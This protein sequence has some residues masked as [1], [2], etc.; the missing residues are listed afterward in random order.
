MAVTLATG[1]VQIL[2]STRGFQ[3]ALGRELDDE[4][5]RAGERAGDESSKRFSG[6]FAS[7]IKAGAKVAAT[8]F[9]AALAGAAVLGKASID[10]ASDLAEAQSKVNV[11]FG[12][13]AA[14]VT[15]WS[16]TA[17]KRIGAS[18]KVALDAAGGFGNLFTQLGI[19]A[20][21]AGT[22]STSMV[23][24]AADFA[25]FHNADIT[26]VLEAQA[27]AFRGE[28]DSVQRFVPTINA[29]AVEQKA[30]EMGL[31][32]TSG[33]LDAQDKALATQALIM[34][35]AGQATGDFARTSDGLAN[36]QRILSAQFEN[37][38]ASLGEKLI[39]AMTTVV[40][41]I[42]EKV[43]PWVQQL[44][45]KWMP[46]L[47]EG[48]QHVSDWVRTN[49]PQ[50]RDT[51]KSVM[52]AVR[53]VI[54][55]AVDIIR[56]IWENFG[57]QIR[58]IAEGKFKMIIGVIRGGFEIVRGIFETVSALL[59]GDWSGVWD[60]L[61]R[62]VL[63]AWTGIKAIVFEALNTVRQIMSIG[64]EIVGSV[65]RAAWGAISS[66]FRNSVYQPIADAVTG[67]G[68]HIIA[69]FSGAVSAVQRVWNM[70]R[71][72]VKAPINVVI[73]FYNNGIRR[74]WNAVISKIPGVGDLGEVSYLNSGGFV[75]GRGSRDTVPA[76]LTPGEF[77][78]TKDAA[79]QLGPGVLAALNKGGTIDPGIL[80]YAQGGYV[81]SADEALAWA[82]S[83]AGKRYQFPDVGPNTFD[84]SGFTSALIN[85][86]LG[87]NP[88]WRRRHSS[89][90]VG[91]DPALRPGG[92]DNALGLLIGAKGP[93]TRN[94]QGASVGHVAATLAG[95]NM[96]ATP[97]AVIVGPGA[98]GARNG[99][100]SGLFHLPGYGGLSD[101]D[102]AIAGDVSSLKGMSLGGLSAPLG[103]LLQKLFNQLPGMVFDF[104]VKKL[105][106]AIV[107]AITGAVGGLFKAVTP[108]SGGGTVW[109]NGPILAGE[110]GPEFAWA[111]RGQYIQSSDDLMSA[112]TLGSGVS[113]TVAG[114]I[115]G[116]S[117]V[118]QMIRHELRRYDFER[119]ATPVPGGRR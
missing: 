5:G 26:D 31:A 20:E 55:D 56:T 63:G 39:P 87:V 6:R 108:F 70:L 82:R 91:S 89:G 67:L 36:Q 1:Y 112:A 15:E 27:A 19:G 40:Q 93:Y 105:P 107:D 49:W 78:I 84:C 2:P 42:S 102:K 68:N 24:L 22:M 92:G 97:P 66:F 111:S 80:G 103:D 8:G 30:L 37:A 75:P 46:Y 69:S 79:K 90:T 12:E 21:Q 117:G 17:D 32:A 58:S 114:D 113:L 44:A 76:M 109:R 86:I 110:H 106:G 65:W 43:V 14:A 34:E 10:A 7:G 101:A 96:E 71:D 18:R 60:G 33:E 81:K 57:E 3:Q 83:Q 72:I 98:R 53:S 52:D 28:Y 47:Q 61:Q 74:V 77:V 11:V 54:T 85:Y 59:R 9:A 104:F 16:R 99:M 94:T 41:V 100:F 48:F 73:G 38:K 35:G 95:V 50:I 23:D 25:S 13:G 29:A 45:E 51:V 115:V 118:R 64:M 116:D 88:P 4:L 62:I 119:R